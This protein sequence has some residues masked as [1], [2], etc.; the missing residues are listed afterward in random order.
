MQHYQETADAS[1]AAA[2]LMLVINHYKNKFEVCKENEFWIWQKTVT[3]P[4]KTSNI[5]ALALYAKKEKLKIHVIVGDIEYKFSNDREK[6]YTK[7]EIYQA[8]YM[9]NLF[10]QEAKKK[11]KIEQRILEFNEVKEFLKNKKILMLRLNAGTFD[12]SKAI[13]KYMV[14]RGYGNEL[15]LI[16]DTRTGETLKV[17]EGIMKEAFETVKTKCKRDNQAIVFG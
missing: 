4:T 13:T 15:F 12:D 1:H 6:K 5:F 10:Y 7:R 3:L 16:N 14:I 8:K 2:S 17:K 11:F 9:S